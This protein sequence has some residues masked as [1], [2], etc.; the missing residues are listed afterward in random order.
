MG[1][2]VLHQSGIRITDRSLRLFDAVEERPAPPGIGTPHA[3][4]DLPA[5]PGQLLLRRTGQAVLPAACIGARPSARRPGDDRELN[6]VLGEVV[7]QCRSWRLLAADERRPY[8]RV[9]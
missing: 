3:D 9:S 1:H 7:G 5:Q 8:S 4:T 2:V 6:V